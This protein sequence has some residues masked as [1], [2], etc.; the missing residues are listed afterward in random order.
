MSRKKK[1]GIFGIASMQGTDAPTLDIGDARDI[2]PVEPNKSVEAFSAEHEPAGIRC[3]RCQANVWRV[4]DSRPGDGAV[5][6]VRVCQCCGKRVPTKEVP[7][8]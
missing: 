8:G 5:D 1:R 4:V 3:A 2:D 7:L 6:R